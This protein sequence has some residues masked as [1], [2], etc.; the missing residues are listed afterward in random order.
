MADKKTYRW[1]KEEFFR[2]SVLDTKFAEITQQMI[3]EESAK[4]V[5]EVCLK[6]CQAENHLA[7]QC[8]G[9]EV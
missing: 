8:V 1:N 3:D 9:A 4:M 7:H 6:R 2:G 5:D